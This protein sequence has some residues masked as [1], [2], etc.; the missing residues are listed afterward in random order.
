MEGEGG[1]RWMK[2]GREQ[3]EMEGGRE[4][5]DRGNGGTIKVGGRWER[6]KRL[7]RWGEQ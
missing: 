1:G 4:E 2:R 3:R 5:R 6:G 7:E